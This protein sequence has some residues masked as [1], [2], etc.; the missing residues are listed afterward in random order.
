MFFKGPGVE[1]MLTLCLIDIPFRV[2]E[3]RAE[4]LHN[5]ELLFCLLVPEASLRVDLKT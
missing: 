5:Y 3:L 4:L 1:F 2:S